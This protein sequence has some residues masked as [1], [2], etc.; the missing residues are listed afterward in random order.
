M[1]ERIRIEVSQKWPNNVVR[2]TAISGFIF[3]RFFCPAILNPVLF[4]LVEGIAKKQSK[5]ELIVSILDHPDQR[6]NPARTLTL[7]AKTMQNL[8]NLVQLGDKEPWFKSMNDFILANTDRM[9]KC[10]V[11]FAVSRIRQTTHVL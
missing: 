6:N 8:A 4:G 9:Q 1:F 3:L 10:I 7:I 2:Y 5:P 11:E